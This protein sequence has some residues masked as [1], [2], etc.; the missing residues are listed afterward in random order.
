MT[1][2]KAM[3]VVIVAGAVLGFFAPGVW[4]LLVIFWEHL[5]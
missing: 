2:G 4:A 1:F 5:R 3:L